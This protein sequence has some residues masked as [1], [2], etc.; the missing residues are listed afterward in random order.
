VRAPKGKNRR[1]I[2]RCT[3]RE[4]RSASHEE[5]NHTRIGIFRLT[6]TPPVRN[7]TVP[8]GACS[9]TDYV[10]TNSATET[11]PKEFI[12]KGKD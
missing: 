3:S 11:G 12:G 4:N 6:G 9:Q 7:A 2:W 10:I 5:G 1:A 8:L